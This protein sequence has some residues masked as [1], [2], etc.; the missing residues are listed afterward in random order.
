MDIKKEVRKGMKFECNHRALQRPDIK[1]N[2]YIKL[3]CLNTNTSNKCQCCKN[4][5]VYFFN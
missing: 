4:T 5:S 1:L 2:N 3:N